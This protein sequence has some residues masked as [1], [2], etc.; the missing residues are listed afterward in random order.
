MAYFKFENKK[1]FYRIVGHGMPLLL[2]HGNTV[3]SK[4]FSQI[5]TK[6][7]KEF[8]VILIDFPGH[9]K[10]E[11]VDSFE[12]DFWYCNSTVTFALIEHLNLEKVAIVGTSGGALVGINLA[13]EHPEKVSYLI[14]DSFE[15]EYPL[16]S[17]IETIEADRERDKKKWHSKVFWFYCHGFDWKKIVDQDTQVNIAFAKTGLSFFHRSIAE[18]KVPTLITG[19]RKDEYCDHLDEIYNGLKSKNQKL[20]VHL[21]ESG[22]HP[23]MLSTKNSFFV[24]IINKLK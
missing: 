7:A 14:A 6:Y 1:V 16:P 12:T 19:S 2:L 4:M 17:Y 9:G 22:N 3:S 5:I 15:G 13:L 24:L 20:V 8:Q 18:L 10:S 21:F 11:R 23:A